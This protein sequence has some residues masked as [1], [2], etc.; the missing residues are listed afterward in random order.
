MCGITAI[1]SKTSETILPAL[2]ESIYILQNRGYDS[3]GVGYL[4]EAPSSVSAFHEEKISTKECRE[5]GHSCFSYIQEKISIS[6]ASLAMGHTRWATHGVPRKSN[7]HPHTSSLHGSFMLVHNGII[8][9]YLSLKTEL[10]Q[11]GYL[12]HSQTDSEVIVNL[13]DDYYQATHDVVESIYRA[14][15]RLE[16]TYG[17]VIFCKDRPN[18]MYTIRR[19]SP[20]IY[21]EDEERCMIVSEVSG[22]C[23]RFPNYYVLDSKRVYTITQHGLDHHQKNDL[24]VKAIPPSA[25]DYQLGAYTHF[26][27]KEIFEQPSTMWN[28]MNHGGRIQND[29]VKLGGLD[30]LRERLMGT[31]HLIM[32]G[33]GSSFY[34]A[35]LGKRIFQEYRFF[36]TIQVINASDFT[37]D[38][39]PT[40]SS[41]CFIFLSQSGETMDVYQVLKKVKSIQ[42]SITL[43]V[44]N[45]VDS[46]IART[47]DGGVYLNCSRE[48][49]VAST[50]SYTSMYIVLSLIAMWFYQNDTNTNTHTHTHAHTLSHI[51]HRIASHLQ[52]LRHL[53][54]KV[55]SLLQ[56]LEDQTQTYVEALA[57]SPS[58]SL[59]ILGDGRYTPVAYEG[60]LKIKEIAYLHA[61]GL[62]A[63]SLKH[64][65]I[66]LLTQGFP[67]I[68]MV[69]PENQSK[70]MNVYQEVKAREAYVIV[71]TSNAQASHAQKFD[72]EN[73]ILVPHTEY[74]M[75]ICM[76]IVFQY[77]SYAIARRKGLPIDFPRNLAKTVTVV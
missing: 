55:E 24:R 16:G 37:T 10:L 40:Q 71:I 2:I 17:L 56:S 33:S 69:D 53:P 73:N 49:A 22:L 67:V 31:R 9:N 14:S 29:Q 46:L 51:Q 76:A 48:Q 11:R 34:A 26:M 39:V 13:I 38:D 5:D 6:T 41:T 19:G 30:I 35:L 36:E 57:E 27:Q 60:A 68:L 18:T 21:A 20:L 61:E 44:V 42:G 64:G 70:M 32:I 77:L 4:T 12:F 59:F 52:A 50:K 23:G 8:E 47:V 62:P 43:G 1:L 75:E 45:V 66:A 65:P 3:I 54:M 58:Q 25:A 28:A 63:T 7:S 72:F 15:L 74:G